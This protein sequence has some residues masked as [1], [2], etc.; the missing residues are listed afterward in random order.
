MG[1]AEPEGV[2]MVFDDVVES[3]LPQ[4]YRY[5]LRRVGPGLADDLV[6][7]TFSTV[8]QRLESYDEK[9]APLRAWVYGIASNVLRSHWRHEQRLLELDARLRAEPAVGNAMS[10]DPGELGDELSPVVARLLASLGPED[11]NVFLLYAWEDLG[12]GEIGVALGLAD[13]TVRSKLSRIRARFRRELGEAASVSLEVTG[14]GAEGPEHG[15]EED[16]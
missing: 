3:L 9:R 8:A 10:S 13:G 15:I 11:R 16:R 4:L 5:F 6:I 14:P 12:P 2:Q 7:E 1:A